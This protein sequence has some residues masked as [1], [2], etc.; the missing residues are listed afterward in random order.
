[1]QAADL[2]ITPKTRLLFLNSPH[3]PTGAVLRRDEIEA[4]GRLAVHDLWILSDEVYEE[5]V[6]TGTAI[7][8]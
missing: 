2:R 6:Y 8:N 7:R 4:L 1:M 3:N 5:M